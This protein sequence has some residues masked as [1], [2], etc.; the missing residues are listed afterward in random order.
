VPHSTLPLLTVVFFASELTLAIVKRSRR[1]DGAT[2][3]D[4]GSGPVLW[5]VITAAIT[6]AAG[7]AD[8]GPGRF[9]CPAVWSRTVAMTLLVGGLTFRWWAVITLGR[10]F[11]VDVATHADHALVDTGPFRYARHPS[12]T[13]LLLAFLGLGVSFGNWLSVA[14]LMVPIVLALAYRMRVE[15]K[16]LRQVLGAPYDAYCARTKRLIPGIL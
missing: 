14:V 12:Y 11:T 13:G 1:A 3:A 9:S 15:E 7:I 6:T 16:V 2:R 4:G 5:V 10:F 8:Y